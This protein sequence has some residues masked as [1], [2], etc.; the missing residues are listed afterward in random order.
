MK[1]IVLVTMV[2]IIILGSSFTV[3]ARPLSKSGNENAE[4]RKLDALMRI[5]D[6]LVERIGEDPSEWPPGL[7]ESLIIYGLLR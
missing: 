5:R 4:E 1:K 6:R 2:V 7:V 3:L